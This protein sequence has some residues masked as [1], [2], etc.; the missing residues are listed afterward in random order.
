MKSASRR[1]KR[2][3]TESEIESIE[4]SAQT[5]EEKK[6]K[7]M[8]A[9]LSRFPLKRKAATTAE[10]GHR[11][12]IHYRDAFRKKGCSVLSLCP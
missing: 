8:K 1:R 9:P 3:G 4:I 5:K 10:R 7:A 6:K 11:R 2:G 12:R